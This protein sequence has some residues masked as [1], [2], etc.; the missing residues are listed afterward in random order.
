MQASLP[1]RSPTVPMMSWT[2]FTLRFL[3]IDL[4][5]L[6]ADPCG[7]VVEAEV[8]I[9]SIDVNWRVPACHFALPNIRRYHCQAF[10]QRRTYDRYRPS[11][12]SMSYLA[13]RLA[14]SA[15]PTKARTTASTRKVRIVCIAKA[16]RPPVC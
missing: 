2:A 7:N 14:S 11:I 6:R 1:V 13:C 4:A 5:T 3:E 9:F 16:L 15:M 12:S 8:D 10:V